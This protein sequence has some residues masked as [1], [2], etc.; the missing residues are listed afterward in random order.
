MFSRCKAQP[1]LCKMTTFLQIRPA[2]KHPNKDNNTCPIQN[3][4][5]HLQPC[6][7]ALQLSFHPSNLQFNLPSRY[8]PP[9]NS[10]GPPPRTR[11][12]LEF[13]SGGCERRDVNIVD[14]N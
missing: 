6:S 10:S 4:R 9:P 14:G 1:T 11:T 5:I 12:F 2:P 3:Q 8:N 13:K 7:H